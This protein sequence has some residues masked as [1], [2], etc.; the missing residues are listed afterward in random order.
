MVSSEKKT[1]IEQQA[2]AVLK[3]FFG[4][5]T[6][7]PNQ[8]GIISGICAG[9]D[10]LVLMPTGGGK[11][12]CYQIPALLLPGVTIVVSPLIAL[13]EDQVQ[14]LRA[15]GI[16]A[17]ALH[18]NRTDAQNAEVYEA[19]RRGHL[20]LLYVSPERL[21]SDLDSGALPAAVSLFAIDE[22]HCISQWGHDFRPEYTQLA[23]IK[24]AFPSVPVVALTAT[25]DKLTRRDISRQLNLRNPAVFISSF[26]RPN[27]SLTVKQNPGRQMK[28]KQI[29]DLIDRYPD[30]SGI[31]YCLSRKTT[32]QMAAELDVRGY[33]VAVYHAGLTP[34]Q[35]SEAQRRF[36]QGDVQVVCATIAFGMGIDKSNIRYVVHNNLPRNI[37]GY[38]QEI[39]RAGRDG[40]P[41]EALMFYS[42][43]DIATLQSF[44]D[45]SGQKE[46]N[47]EKLSRMREYA[48]ASVCRRRILLSYFSEETTADCGNCDVCR[49][50]PLRFDGTV[51][52]QKALSAIIRTDQSV[53]VNMLI[54]ILRGSARAE[55]IAK[56][57]D[58]IKTYAAGRD[59]GVAHWR[60]YLSQMLQLGLIEVAY[61][62]ANHLKV[63][64]QGLRVVH[65][66][67]RVTLAQFL[68]EHIE[69]KQKTPKPKPAAA[70][71]PNGQLVKRL[72][73]L[74]SNLAK[75][76]GL[77]PYMIFSDRTLLSIA[78]LRPVSKQEFAQ[79]YGV[80]EYKTE[81]YWEQFT[82]VVRM[83]QAEHPTVI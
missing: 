76:Q 58:K 49:Q 59:L 26:D 11:S 53:G 30:D 81:K 72:K 68:Y 45:E 8:L 65:G 27:I 77:A 74:R 25:A 38:Y 80:G 36:I 60:A 63:T 10:S 33:S 21:I 16:P 35:R 18:S 4:Y 50:P 46:I 78:S 28:L 2:H 70:A 57:Y 15:N 43:Q 42:F 31:I 34:E 37:E 62:E 47:R 14:A 67:E 69:P 32:E 54:D 5:D 83:W 52:A 48:E 44:I 23:R 13:M 3:R 64:P 75:I 22:A 6:F 51:V 39:G 19:L 41:A 73:E 79:V 9:R 29:C 7:R 24:E 12:L 56:G 55:L 40:L 61:N 71:N 66:Q 82:R 17:A 1:P 20:K